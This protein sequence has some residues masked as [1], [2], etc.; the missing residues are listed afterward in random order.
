MTA[1]QLISTMAFSMQTAQFA[2]EHSERNNALDAAL[3]S[4]TIALKMEADY[5]QANVGERRRS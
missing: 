2:L 3:S 1:E 5:W 4:L